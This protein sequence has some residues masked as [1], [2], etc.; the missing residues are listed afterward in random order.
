MTVGRSPDG[1]TARGRG[2]SAGWS[3]RAGDP[4]RP[5]AGVPR[6]SPAR[7]A[8]AG[9]ARV[10]RARAP[11]APSPVHVPPVPGGPGPPWRPPALLEDRRSG[12]G[13]RDVAG[14]APAAGP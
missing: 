3:R 10:L 1:T 8:S 4:A 13:P 6:S 5:L 9:P 14:V 11:L 12:P 7:T 2:S